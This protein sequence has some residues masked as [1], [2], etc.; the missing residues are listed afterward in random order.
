MRN[1]GEQAQNKGKRKTPLPPGGG[2]A[3]RAHQ[4]EIERGVEGHGNVE[5]EPDESPRAGGGDE[6]RGDE[7]K[8]ESQGEAACERT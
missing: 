3:G 2:A 1:P 8:G 6:Q 7:Q 4:F 5:S